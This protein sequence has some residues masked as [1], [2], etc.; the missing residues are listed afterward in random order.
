VRIAS[1][2]P[3]PCGDCFWAGGGLHRCRQGNCW[4]P[5]PSPN[6]GFRHFVPVTPEAVLKASF[7]N[8]QVEDHTRREGKPNGV[9]SGSS[10]WFRSA[11][12]CSVDLSLACLPCW[13]VTALAIFWECLQEQDA[14][15][16]WSCLLEA[17]CRAPAAKSLVIISPLGPHGSSGYGSATLEGRAASPGPAQSASHWACCSCSL[18]IICGWRLRRNCSITG[19]ATCRRKLASSLR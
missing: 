19:S 8:L 6:T 13:G 14:R 16:G 7:L 11:A 9:A 15:E 17:C 12:G 10:S 4:R 2:T 3:E 18:P 1:A 5:R